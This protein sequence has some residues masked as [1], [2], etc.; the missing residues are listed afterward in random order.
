[1]IFKS[2]EDF[3]YGITSSAMSLCDVN[4]SGGRLKLYAF[5]IMSNHVHNL[6]CGSKEDCL[7]YFRIWK[8]RLQRY[9]AGTIELSKFN[10]NIQSIDNLQSFRLELAYINRNGFVNNLQEIPFSYEWTSGRYHFNPVTKEISM[11]RVAEIS[12]REKKKLFRTRVTE[13]YDSMLLHKDYI[14]PLSF[15]EIE[16]GENLYNTPH[17]YFKYLTKAVEEYSLI[18]KRLGDN[19]F[20]ND[21]EMFNVTYKIA[22]EIYH[23]DDPKLLGAEEKIE[24]A[25][26]MHNKYHASNSQISRILKLD[27]HLLEILFP[28]PA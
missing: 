5:A 10:C 21:S 27:R 6:V 7:Q 15:C 13:L 28:K 14:S 20:L 3:K 8:G 24:V 17:Q 18:A 11:K 1:M 4:Q 12:C 23:A 26:I 22:K 9:F 25:K 19:I 2:E 16:E